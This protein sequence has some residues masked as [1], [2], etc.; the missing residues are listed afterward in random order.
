VGTVDVYNALTGPVHAA[1]GCKAPFS[2]F[3]VWG[4]GGI[5]TGM[6][7]D[8]MIIKQ[9]HELLKLEFGGVCLN[10]IVTIDGI[11]YMVTETS[12]FMEHGVRMEQQ[13]LDPTLGQEA[14]R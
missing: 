11:R 6:G 1:A 14:E 4:K 13:I 8:E 9:K 5:K 12:E 3:P 7:G 2:V 10:D